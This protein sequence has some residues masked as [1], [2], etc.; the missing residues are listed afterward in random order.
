L[1]SVERHG[2]QLKATLENE[3]CEKVEERLVDRVVVDAG[4]LPMDELY[5]AL[6][7]QSINSGETDLTAFVAAER[8][9]ALDRL[10]GSDD[11]FALFRIGDAVATRG[12]HAAIFDAVR[13]CTAL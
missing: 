5:T 12:L 3:Y 7:P 4:T 1:L 2:N 11:V 8:Q 6:A 13:L 9:P 10:D